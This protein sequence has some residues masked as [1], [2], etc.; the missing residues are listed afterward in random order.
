MNNRFTIE[1]LRKLGYISYAEQFKDGVPMCSLDDCNGPEDIPGYG[2]DDF[3]EV[4]KLYCSSFVDGSLPN[5]VNPEIS[6]N[7]PTEV[8]KYFAA[9]SS[10]NMATLMAAPD[11]DV[12][13][14]TIIPR[15]STYAQYRSAARQII[16]H[17]SDIYKS[18]SSE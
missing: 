14:D 4:L 16:R 13:F 9:I 12:A 5:W 7:A 15:D 3:L 17:Y 2:F 18:K 10:K 1:Q 6:D 11:D 8:K